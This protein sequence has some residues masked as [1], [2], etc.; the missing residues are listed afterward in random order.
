MSVPELPTRR[1]RLVPATATLVRAEMAGRERLAPMLRAAVPD[2]WPPETL[3]DALPFFLA[4]LEADP[5]SV[6][7]YAWYGLVRT[8]EPEQ[9]LLVANGG[10]KGPPRGGVAEVG[11]AV[12]EA[13]QGR[14]YA[15]EMVT[16]LVGWALRRPGVERVVAETMPDNRP[17]IRVL[18][19]VGFQPA[20]PGEEPGSLRFE[21]HPTGRLSAGRTT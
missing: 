6:G 3:A 13:F 8:A 12:L 7:W 9:A 2:A 14:G 21:L 1:M 16:A 20:G 4:R 18:E 19:K 17:S 11:Y 15:T 10:F 5:A